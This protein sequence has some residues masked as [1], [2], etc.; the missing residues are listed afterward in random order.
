MNLLKLRTQFVKISGRYDLVVDQTDWADN[1]ADFYIQAGQNFLD[2]LRDTPKS[3]NSIF[4]KLESG[5]WYVAFSKCRSIREVWINNT[6][7]RSE[8]EKKPMNWL[9]G[10]YSSTVA[11]TDRGTPLYYCP[12]KL[13]SIDNV[14]QDDLGV[15]FNYTE[16]G[17]N[18]F[19]GI[20]IF[21]APDED[22]VVEL[23]GLFYSDALNQD[24]STSYWTD[25]WPETLVKATMHQLATFQRDHTDATNWLRA[26]HGD[27]EGI[28]KDGVDE[29]I[30]DITQ[31]K[32]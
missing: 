8:L 3:Y 10:E 5:E 14:D 30:S 12:A 24:S 23:Q 22:V 7:G 29:M 9:Y 13:R 32:G 6:A 1:G 17:S 16:D 15:F 28:D 31:I 21:G 26:I 18:E 27:L 20:L 4:T 19:R 11:D 25:N 2:R